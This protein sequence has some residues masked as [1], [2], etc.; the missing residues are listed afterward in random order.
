[1]T[2]V[3]CLN[4]LLTDANCLLFLKGIPMSPAMSLHFIQ[5]GPGYSAA[6]KVQLIKGGASYFQMMESLLDEAK[7]SVHLQVYIF[8]GDETGNRIIE[9]LLRAA[10]RKVHVYLLLD[11]YASKEFPLEA[12]QRLKQAGAHF[13]WFSP[14]LRGKGFYVG[15]R[16]HHKILVVDGIHSLVGGLNIS[17][18]YNDLPGQPAWLDWS[19]YVVGEASLEIL[20]RCRQLWRK[21]IF[22]NNTLF[23]PIQWRGQ[24]EK[25]EECLVRIR[26][27]DWV[28]GKNQISRSYLEWLH[29]SRQEVIMMSSYFLPG[30][31]LRKNLARAAKRGVRIKLIL[32]RYSDVALAKAA[33]NYLYTWLLQQGIEIYEYQKNILHGKV[34]V[35]DAQWATIGSY[36]LNNISAYASVELNVDVYNAAFG[37][38]LRKQLN[39]VILEDCV[40]VRAATF[41]QRL[42][43]WKRVQ[44][45]TAYQLVRLIFFLFTFYFTQE[46]RAFGKKLHI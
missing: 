5:R 28:R 14:L 24:K 35:F 18:R 7:Y 3:I 11:A 32:A 15:R 12:I 45:W 4:L 46:K 13:K 30:R 17:N 42:T 40:Q 44:Q 26:V 34:A 2:K 43:W 10:Q 19:I 41:F 27:N 36:N 16:M 38:T 8:D 37:Q 6:N 31:V 33:E 9:A 29:R 22:K 23:E 39:S 21:R 1:M 20:A 25:T